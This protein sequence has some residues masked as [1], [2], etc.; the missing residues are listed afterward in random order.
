MFL[1][2]LVKD[3]NSLQYCP[4]NVS[5]MICMML[6]SLLLLIIC[7]SYFIFFFI[8]LAEILLL[9]LFPKNEEEYSSCILAIILHHSYWHL[10][11]LYDNFVF[12]QGNYNSIVELLISLLLFV[13]FSITLISGLVFIIS[14]LFWL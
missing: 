12:Y 9:S 14:F 3:K 4:F 13:L 8:N 11:E 1:N 5:I 6:L 2:L 10:D 7:A